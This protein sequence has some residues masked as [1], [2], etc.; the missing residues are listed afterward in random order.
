MSQPMGWFFIGWLETSNKVEI[1][2][3]EL[4]Y[5][6]NQMKDTSKCRFEK[7]DKKH[8]NKFVW[9]KNWSNNV[10]GV[11][12]YVPLEQLYSTIKILTPQSSFT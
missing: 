5:V 11:G 4:Y 8:Q 1:I 6:L 7:S 2:N 9:G 10:V 3:Y 12:M